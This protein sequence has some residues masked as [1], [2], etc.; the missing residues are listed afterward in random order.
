MRDQGK[1]I[2]R[3]FVAKEEKPLRQCALAG[4][5]KTTKKKKTAT[6]PPR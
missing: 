6:M 4:K 1:N 3:L 5:K 2:I